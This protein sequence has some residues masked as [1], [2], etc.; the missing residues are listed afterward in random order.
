MKV[1]Y[2]CPFAQKHGVAR[3]AH[4]YCMALLEAGVEVEIYPMFECDTA[5]LEPQYARLADCLPATEGAADRP[6]VSIVHA[7]PSDIDSV[8]PPGNCEREPYVAVTTWET[9]R[10][11]LQFANL[12][13][14]KFS[15]VLVPSHYTARAFQAMECMVEVQ[16]LPHAIGPA[17]R[18]GREWNSD[19][20]SAYVFYTIG[21]WNERKNPLGLLRAYLTEFQP[22]ENVSLYL[23]TD[24]VDEEAV[25]GLR[26]G[27]NLHDF[28]NV[29]VGSDWL[30]EPGMIH[31]HQRMDC[32]V[33]ATRG[34][35][36]G[37][38]A[39]EACALG[40][41]VIAP[42]EGGQATF[43]S[44]YSG[45]KG[46]V[47]SFQTPAIWNPI[48]GEKTFHI[49]GLNIPVR[50]V[51]QTAPV[52]MDGTQHWL[53]PDL[54]ALQDRMRYMYETRRGR[55]PD[56]NVWGALR[57]SRARKEFFDRYSYAEIGARFRGL[58]ESL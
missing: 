44:N 42:A 16:V 52:G 17:W 37:L 54:A 31:L 25:A 18:T 53:E 58:L 23:K 28:P 57:V 39:F 46:L 12:F 27:T 5:N 13:D 10:L 4:D 30:S 47:G 26:R 38:G 9:S 14:E 50:T 55:D 40:N 34:E 41:P 56:D 7:M 45:D 1:H 29:Y 8:L 22:D 48:G 3:A 33:T 49:G 21:A 19:E 11:P 36:F 51:T 43:L 20:G 6:D 2:V 32:Y 35:G 24:K 15:M